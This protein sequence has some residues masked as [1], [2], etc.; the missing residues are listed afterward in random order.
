MKGLDLDRVEIVKK[1]SDAFL[2]E[3]GQ[4]IAQ[5]NLAEYEAAGDGKYYY[6]DDANG[7][8]LCRDVTN[9]TEVI[10]QALYNPLESL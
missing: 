2:M 9:E 6:T 4:S 8:F 7:K 3:V 5:D 10:Y 1:R